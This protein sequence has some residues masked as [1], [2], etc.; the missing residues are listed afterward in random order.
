MQ[1]DVGSRL[2]VKR[3]SK[4]TVMTKV[5]RRVCIQSPNYISRCTIQPHVGWKRY[6]SLPKILNLVWHNRFW[7]RIIE[8]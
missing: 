5:Q 8:R 2:C 1:K 4:S 6:W 7:Y 3:L